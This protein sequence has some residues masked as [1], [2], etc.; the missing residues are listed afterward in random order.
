MMQN[1]DHRHG[2]S[3][4]TGREAKAKKILSILEAAGRPFG[5][6]HLALD[7]G[8]GSGEIAEIISH[9]GPVI[10][11][12]LIDQRVRP[13][14]TPFAFCSEHLPFCRDTFDLV[15]SNHVI[16]HVTD[17]GL[18]LREIHRVLRPGGTLYLATP[19]RWW[20]RE[21]HSNLPLLHYLRWDWFS[22][23]ASLLGR[24]NEPIRLQSLSSLKGLANSHYHIEVWHPKVITDPD[25]YHLPLPA[26]AA[27]I[28]RHVPETLLHLTAPLHPTLITLMIPR[29]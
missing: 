26:Y 5:A 13:K 22:K 23:L 6:D 19:N 12:D 7:I 1:I 2:F 18:H 27:P 9:T 21:V 29:R 25:Y 11:V 24:T 15:L 17:P 3:V 14:N 8:C 16:E 28:I 10:A 20:P 4:I